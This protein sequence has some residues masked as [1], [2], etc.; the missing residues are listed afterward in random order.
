MKRPALALLVL[1]VLPAMLAGLGAWAQAL[2]LAEVRL[3]PGFTIEVYASGLPSARGL[4]FSD[5]GTLFVGSWSGQVYAVPPGGG[6]GRVIADGLDMPVG[7]AWHR[8]DLYVSSIYRVVKLAAVETSPSPRPVDL[9]DD[10]PRERHHGW[11]F[12]KIGP[13]GKL[14]VP[15]GAPCNVCESQGNRYANILRM[16][17]DGGNR[18]LFAAGVRNTVGFDWHPQTGELWFTDNGRDLLGDELPPDELNRA[19]RPGLHFG[20]P[21]LHGRAVRDPLFWDSRPAVDFRPPELELPAH[22]AALGM[23]FYTGELFPAEYRGGIFIAEHGSWNRSKKIGYRVS[24]VRLAADRVVEYRSFAQ[25][26]LQ[27]ERAWGR[28]ADVEVGPDGALYVS[29]D[30]ADAVY[31]IGYSR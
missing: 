9:I 30:A 27:G 10:L 8:G 18:E 17:L 28:P 14:Y 15:V 11:K 20:F 6:R 16:D 7:V 5:S 1:L 3:P 23:R 22:V 4:A 19:P 31:R 12:I 29:D 24:F 21:Y 13:D 26:W 2:P 25:G